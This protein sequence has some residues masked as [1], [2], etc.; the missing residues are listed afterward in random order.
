MA[1]DPAANKPTIF[2]Y[3]KQLIIRELNESRLDEMAILEIYIIIR[4]CNLY[5]VPC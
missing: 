5:L 1:K 3:G 2:L 4:T